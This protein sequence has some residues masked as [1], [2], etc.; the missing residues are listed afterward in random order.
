[1]N[2]LARKFAEKWVNET[3]TLID[4]PVAKDLAVA[5]I[6]N[7]LMTYVIELNSENERLKEALELV[8]TYM[9]DTCPLDEAVCNAVEAALTNGCNKDE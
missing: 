7:L 9:R 2:T 4:S 3:I 5:S 1:M 8:K 6:E